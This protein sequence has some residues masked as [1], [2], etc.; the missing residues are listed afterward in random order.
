MKYSY[1]TAMMFRMFTIMFISLFIVVLC[2][3]SGMRFI[4][5]TVNCKAARLDLD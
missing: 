3:V 2:D 4:M 5:Q 1:L